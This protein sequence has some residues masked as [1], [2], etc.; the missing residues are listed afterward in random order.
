MKEEILDKLFENQ[1]IKYAEFHKRIVPD[2]KYEIIG[3][4]LPIMRK[5]AKEFIKRDDFD[6]IVLDKNIK[7]YEEAMIQG[8]MIGYK[9]MTLK[10][11]EKYIKSYIP[12]MDTWAL[13]DS[14]IPTFKIKDNEREEYLKFILNYKDSPKE[15]YARFFIISILD[16][17]IYDEMIDKDIEYLD[18]IKNDKYYVQMAKAWCLAEIATNN[19]DKIIKYL[20]GNNNL[21]KFTHNKTIQKMIE[22]FRFTDEQKKYIKSLKREN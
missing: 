17:F 4:R 6:E 9:K 8:L 13:T 14:V 1:D 3:I 12:K 16:Y 20:T 5:L 22:S 10:D 15:Y 19:Y 11:K 2:T 18:S 21:D 7:Y